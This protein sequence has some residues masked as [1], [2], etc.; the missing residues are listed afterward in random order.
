MMCLQCPKPVV[1]AVHGVCVEAGVD[2]I[3]AC[4]IRLCTQDAWFQVKSMIA[5]ALEIAGEIAGRV[6][7]LSREPKST[8]ST[9]ETTV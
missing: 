4:D 7:S 1:V 9:P 8:S 2:L 3:T 6:P 5:G